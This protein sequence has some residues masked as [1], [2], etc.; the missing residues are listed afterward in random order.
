MSKVHDEMMIKL[1]IDGMKVYTRLDTFIKENEFTGTELK[2]MRRCL[3]EG[4]AYHGGG[5]AF[6]YW[7]MEA[8]R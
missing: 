1:T 3:K 8:D 5:G 7:K 2:D 4:K 6:A